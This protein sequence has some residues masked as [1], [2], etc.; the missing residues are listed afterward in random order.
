MSLMPEKNQQSSN[1]SKANQELDIEEEIKDVAFYQMPERFILSKQAK[2]QSKKFNWKL[3]L[4]SSIVFALFA[5]IISFY[6][7]NYSQKKPNKSVDNPK[8]D[9]SQDVD[10]NNS[11]GSPKEKYLQYNKE[12]FGA[13]NLEGY[14]KFLNNNGSQARIAEYNAQKEKIANW[15]EAG[16]NELFLSLKKGVA[17]QEEIKNIQEI[18][19]GTEATLDILLA[20]GQHASVKLI[21]E[22]STWKLDK[23]YWPD[24]GSG[25]SLDFLI[26]NIDSSLTTASSSVATTTETTAATST[27][28]M[29][30]TTE[31][32][33]STST[34]E[35]AS[36]S[37]PVVATSTIVE[38]FLDS[39]GDGLSDKEELILGTDSAKTDSDSD[40]YGDSAE[41]N[42]L[43][44]PAGTGKINSNKGLTIYLN[45]KYNYSTLYPVSWIKQDIDE[46]N[47]IIFMA[48]NGQFFQVA[49]QPNP[50][51]QSITDWYKEQFKQDT[52]NESDIIM[53]NNW[54]GVRVNNGLDVYVTDKQKNNI[55]VLS[56][57]M[58]AVKSQD[59]LNLF[60]LFIKSFIWK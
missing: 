24:A 8:T 22:S 3:M 12:L 47:S 53:G 23:E 33:V 43:Y 39:D 25:N 30:S 48:D 46:G 7:L 9:S 32:V 27:E 45:S 14:E 37:T 44:N 58:G 19:N 52:I 5:A 21:L 60:N 13:L 31:P 17:S 34:P 38:A 41:L 26:Q 18:I 59:Y 10:N 51:Q 29:A 2:N 16:K 4:I 15:P 49:T 50:S 54:D 6:F 11:V 57:S 36:T 20:S 1:Q 55:I 28:E 40:S 56:Y 42:G 35:V